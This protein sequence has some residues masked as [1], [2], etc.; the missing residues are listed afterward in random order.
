MS[1]AEKQ[2]PSGALEPTD[3]HGE[4]LRTVE[5]KC[6]GLIEADIR[7]R[8]P[9][10]YGEIQDLGLALDN[11]LLD[12]V[13][14]ASAMQ[15]SHPETAEQAFEAAASIYDDSKRVR[16]DTAEE[17]EQTWRY[18][19]SDAATHFE[20]LRKKMAQQRGTFY[21]IGGEAHR[22]FLEQ[23]A[24][25]DPFFTDEEL[26][27]PREV[28]RV[29]IEETPYPFDVLARRVDVRLLLRKRMDQITEQGTIL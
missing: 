26:T 1:K 6:F 22:I 12:F 15:D 19:F 27:V 11:G 24:E 9:D 5:A 8:R 18:R 14:L 21:A 16:S 10:I 25:I 28:Y 2:L 29:V 3:S 23:I 7:L 17:R 13:S 4:L 20:M